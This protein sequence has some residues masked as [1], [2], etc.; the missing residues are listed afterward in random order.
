MGMNYTQN[1]AKALKIVNAWNAGNADEPKKEEN[2]TSTD[3][4]NLFKADVKS[5]K[6]RLFIS[7]F[8]STQHELDTI[9]NDLLDASDDDSLEIYISSPGGYTWDL[10]KVENMIR[11]KFYGRCS[12]ILN[13]YGYSCGALMF[14]CGDS[15][16]IYE[17]SELMFH[18]ISTFMGGKLSDIATE[19]KHTQ[20][21]YEAYQKRALSPYFTKNE[22]KDLLDGKEF[23][24]DAL[25]ICERKICTSIS[26]F[27]ARMA[28]DLYVE[29]RKSKATRKDLMKELKNLK[30]SKKDFDFLN[31]KGQT[32]NK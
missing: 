23:W 13:S 21:L 16:I 25:E 4:H 24:L 32:S 14:L 26:V 20:K 1:G 5:T 7:E 11:E 10:M 30:L 3:N 27:G 31:T 22:I 28:P 9:Y 8:N 29:Y 12:T 18:N 15:R 19:F 6:Y 2:F 17:N